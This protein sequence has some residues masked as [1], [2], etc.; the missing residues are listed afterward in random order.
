MADVRSWCNF[1]RPNGTDEF[2]D[3]IA[4]SISRSLLVSAWFARSARKPS[5]SFLSLNPS[6]LPHNFRHI[7]AQIGSMVDLSDW[8]FPRSLEILQI[9]WNFANWEHRNLMIAERNSNFELSNIG[10]IHILWIFQ[11]WSDISY[12][13]ILN[14]AWISFQGNINLFS[15]IITHCTINFTLI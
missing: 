12:F 1:C 8:R 2:V 14:I 6:N 3:G 10:W 5:R 9:T 15:N 13:R 7:A 11:S 4:N